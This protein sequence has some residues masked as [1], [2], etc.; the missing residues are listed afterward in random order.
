MPTNTI[1]DLEALLEELGLKTPI[2][3]VPAADVLNKPLD[4]ARCYLADIFSGIT[5]SDAEATYSAIHWPNDIFKGDLAVILPRLVH[6]ADANVL[7]FEL[8]QK[9]TWLLF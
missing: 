6:G 1:A 4:I 3:H 5:D 9:V 8:M 7:A 2:P